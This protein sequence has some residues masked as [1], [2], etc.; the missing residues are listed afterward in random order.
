VSVEAMTSVW[1]HSKAKRGGLLV[2]LALADHAHDDGTNAY[3][4]VRTLARKARLSE[5]GVQKAL[6]ALEAIREIEPTGVSSTGTVVYAIT[7]PMGGEQTSDA[8]TTGEE[9]DAEGANSA[10]DRLSQSSPEPSKD[11]R[12]KN[13]QGA[14][15]SARSPARGKRSAKGLRHP[16]DTRVEEWEQRADAWE[17][18]EQG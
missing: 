2:M 13:R 18:E 10:A 1:R 11:N 17:Q 3:P 7:L 8:E 12:P 9:T 6:R 16:A 5:R 14:R 4:S 15:A